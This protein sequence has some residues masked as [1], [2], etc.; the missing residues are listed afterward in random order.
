MRFLTFYTLG[1]TALSLCACLPVDPLGEL[2]MGSGSV[3]RSQDGSTTF[4]YV[5]HADAHA[6]T[7]SEIRA[8]HQTLI[9]NYLAKG[10]YCEGGYTITS[11]NFEAS[12]PAYVYEG[13]CL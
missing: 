8:V 1:L 13:R 10:G 11:D 4:R 6:G 5:I 2:A 7:A 3:N 9:G 12:V